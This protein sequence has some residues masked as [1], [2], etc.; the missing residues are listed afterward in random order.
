[1]TPALH[2]MPLKLNEPTSSRNWNSLQIIHA[3]DGVGENSE[4]LT[5]RKSI[6]LHLFMPL[7]GSSSLFRSSN[8]L[9][10][11]N[12]IVWNSSR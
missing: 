10:V 3:S 8:F 5:T 4:Q 6:F 7:F 9:I 11:G 1:M 12:T 2:P